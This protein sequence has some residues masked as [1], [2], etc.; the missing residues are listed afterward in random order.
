MGGDGH[1]K[2]HAVLQFCFVHG[3]QVA[4]D[5]YIEDYFVNT[6]IHVEWDNDHLRA[7]VADTMTLAKKEFRAP[8]DYPVVVNMPWA[9][10]DDGVFP[11]NLVDTA[12]AL[13][14]ALIRVEGNGGTRS[15][16]TCPL[17]MP[18]TCAGRWVFSI[19]STRRLRGRST[20]NKNYVR[21]TRV[22]IKY[23]INRKTSS[24]L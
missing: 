6:D 1:V 4:E 23:R 22:S 20:S 11:P 17:P 14:H 15:A 8:I 12:F 2:G 10:S 9:Y 5:P 13:V 24:D 7:A 21:F 18:M 3:K 16:S 19:R